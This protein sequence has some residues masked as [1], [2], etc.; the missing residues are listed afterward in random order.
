MYAYVS[1]EYVYIRR[2]ASVG[3]I[4]QKRNRRKHSIDI[5]NIGNTTFSNEILFWLCVRCESICCVFVIL[6]ISNPCE[7][8]S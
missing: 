3:K 5:F 1:Y 2:T 6:H 8:F 4:Q 7:K